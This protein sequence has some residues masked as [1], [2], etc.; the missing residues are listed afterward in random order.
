M[1]TNLSE[2]QHQ[3]ALFSWAKKYP[4]LD[5]MF[6]IPNEGKRSGYTGA[7]HKAMGLKSGVPDI[8]LPLSKQGYHGLFIELKKDDKQKISPNQKKWMEKLSI[9]GYKAVACFSWE[10]ARK[11]L[12]DYMEVS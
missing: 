10:E 9:N 8:M 12:I 4:E 6:A 11:A 5:V 2:S 1:I 7:K 3:Q